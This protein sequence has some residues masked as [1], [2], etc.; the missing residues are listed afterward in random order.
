M[1]VTGFN[2]SGRKVGSDISDG[3]FVIEVLTVTSPKEGGLLTSGEPYRITWTTRET[4]HPV[5]KVKLYYTTNGG[6][7]W[8]PIRETI[9]ENLGYYDWTPSAGKTKKKCKV[10]VVLKDEDG[11]S[12]ASDL[13]DGYFTIENSDEPR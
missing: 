4:K 7:T 2:S 10:K 11:N 12:V 8:L 1:K 5:S 13:S 3:T 6:A 9:T